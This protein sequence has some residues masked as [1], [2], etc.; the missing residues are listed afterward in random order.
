[1]A[2]PHST[3]AYDLPG[4]DTCWC[5]Q[6]EVEIVWS[7]RF[8]RS[9]VI[10]NFVLLRCSSC[11]QLRS[12]PQ[13]GVQA[14][15]GDGPGGTFINEEANIWEIDNARRIARSG[16]SGSVLGVGANTG[17]LMEFLAGHGFGPLTGLEPNDACAQQAR[18]AG[19]DVVTGWFTEDETPPGPFDVIV[20]SHVL[21]HIREPIEALALARDRLR[22]GGLLAIFVPNAASYRARAGWSR[23]GPFNPIDHVWHFEP[24]PLRALFDEVDGLT[25]Q[26]MATSRLRAARYNSLRRIRHA[27]AEKIGTWRG[28]AE[29][30]I[31]MAVKTP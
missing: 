22:P 9:N 29:Q 10:E 11:D 26:T 15:H 25:L 7:G 18:N 27:I 1:M 21:E 4:L 30:L 12:G 6:T 23:W 3:D 5:G 16:P 19:L 20:I 31:V 13:T 24:V 28:R 8:D 17:K 2:L 14:S